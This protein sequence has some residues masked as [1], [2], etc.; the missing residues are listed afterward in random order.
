MRKSLDDFYR[1]MALLPLLIFFILY[2]DYFMQAELSLL[3]QCTMG[4]VLLVS[5]FIFAKKPKMLRYLLVVLSVAVIVWFSVGVALKYAAIQSWT[6]LET[7]QNQATQQMI[8][9]S[10]SPVEAQLMPVKHYLS[11]LYTVKFQS[12]NN[13]GDTDHALETQTADSQTSE[14]I[15]KGYAWLFSL[16]M[17]ALTLVLLNIVVHFKPLRVL[18]LLP[19]IHFIWLWYGYIDMPLRL[20]Q[21]YIIGMLCYI[22]SAQMVILKAENPEYESTH[23]PQKEVLKWS[24]IM[25]ITALMTAGVLMLI[26]PI[27]Q[28]NDSVGPLLPNVWGARTSLGGGQFKMF[29]LDDTAYQ[30]SNQQLGGP[31]LAIDR[32]TV[33]FQI[34]FDTAPHEAVYLRANVKDYYSGVNWES[35][36]NTYAPNFESYF[37]NV[38]NKQ[39]VKTTDDRKQSGTVQFKTMRSLTLFAPIGLYATDLDPSRVYASHDNEA[40]YKAGTFVKALETYHFDSTGHDFGY[41]DEVNYRQL[42]EG[43]DEEVYKLA[44]KLTVGASTDE[45]R[46][47]ALTRYLVNTYPYTLTPSPF[48]GTSD[49]VSTFL[50]TTKEGYCTYFASAL[51]VMARMNN[52]PARY[53]EGFRVSPAANET[54]YT[55]TEGEA[56]AWVEVFLEGQG[57]TVWEAT[58]PY[59][60]LPQ[61]EDEA[62]Q[63]NR[64]DAPD[65]SAAALTGENA[66]QQNRLALKEA[67][68]EAEMAIVSDA[69]E[70]TEDG[71]NSDSEND[72]AWGSEIWYVLWMMARLLMLILMLVFAIVLARNLSIGT[73][74]RTRERVIQKI[75]Y[76]ERLIQVTEDETLFG[77]ADNV[78]AAI[79]PESHACFEQL[80]YDRP[81][82]I[83]ESVVAVADQMVKS[84]IKAQYKGYRERYGL[85]RY[86]C[87]RGFRV[88]KHW[89]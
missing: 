45:A 22:G 40:F 7:T 75:G 64:H 72:A 74:K 58:P 89:Q 83:T 34:T 20:F 32:E 55:V 87:F 80:K 56:H 24:L 19:L 8:R 23:Y 43:I 21:S 1:H 53:V 71:L 60:I 62:T 65:Q 11:W 57:W 18:L 68:M 73:G 76:L 70:S 12:L 5:C 63:G 86:M 33:C 47:K 66:D 50:L 37:S 44:A 9:P 25:G 4:A 42:P 61:L 67:L 41:F 49:F 6:V 79:T 30:S 17:S 88:S 13:D 15:P 84:L 36:A 46:M 54:V 69:D 35:H 3:L 14:V 16:M 2:R 85:I 27:K 48:S 29:T 38:Q 82:R 77:I 31:I 28:I 59:S 78:Q 52:I 51:A 26:L 10:E 39:A 81:D